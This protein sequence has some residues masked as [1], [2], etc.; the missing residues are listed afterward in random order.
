MDLSLFSKHWTCFIKKCSEFL[1]NARRFLKNTD[2]V[3]ARIQEQLMKGQLEIQEWEAALETG[4]ALTET[5]RYEDYSI[6]DY[7]MGLE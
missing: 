2:V 4:E 3:F 1:T 5:Y 6:V 7:C